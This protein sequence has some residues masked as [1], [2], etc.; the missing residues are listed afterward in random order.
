MTFAEK[1]IFLMKLTATS[2]KQ[3]ALA[4]KV[5][6]SLISLL[7]TARRDAPKNAAHIRAMA[8]YFAKKCAGN[9]QR[10]ALSEALGRK[11]L[12]LQ[13]DTEQLSSILFDWLTDRR[14]R[15]GQFL[16]TFEQFSLSTP[17]DAES[18]QETGEAGANDSR[19][20]AFYGN[21]GKRSAVSAFVSR[22]LELDASGTV[23]F[24]TDENLEWL[25]ENTSFLR[26]LQER[27]LMLLQ[28]GYHICRIA[29]PV[30]TT[31]QAFDS[32]TQLLPLYLTGQV[33]SYYYPQLRDN[34]YHRSLFIL[35]GTAAVA[36]VSVG[37]ASLSRATLFAQDKRYVAALTA[38]FHDLLAKCRPMMTTYS[39]VG[40]S[41]ELLRCIA[42]FES[43]KG[44]RIQQSVTLSSITAPTKLNQLA[45]A[46]LPSK[47]ASDVMDALQQAQALF[48]QSL[49]EY[50]VIDIHS[51]ATADEVRAGTIP[52]AT[53]YLGQ[54]PPVTYTPE[55]YAL[56]LE[57]ILE[58]MDSFPNYHAYLH[59]YD[60]KT[61]SLM[62]KDGRQA[63][64]LRPGTPLMVF[65]V[66]QPYIAESC[67]A[68]LMR[69]IKTPFSPEVQ[70]Q[71]VMLQLR[72]RISELRR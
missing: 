38:E 48:R 66:S 37:N 8:T 15:V 62:V 71:N 49:A 30:Y 32:L 6:P 68:Y 40:N 59:G 22:L 16:N 70:R 28:R 41:D 11:Q 65:E 10:I 21:E 43:D 63:L 46:D 35:P 7:R 42:Q 26:S 5:D 13:M 17:V 53:G 57:S 39:T 60:G 47:E 61:H 58:Y 55:T 36:S 69:L 24:S 44:N 29:P 51:L 3:P 33:E 34:V 4:V 12:Q 9:Y 67:R 25:Y 1:L 64:L 56:H 31:E 18:M 19:S 72:Q 50:E 2:N 14:D 27:M 45:L 54:K 52:V 20:F 23:L